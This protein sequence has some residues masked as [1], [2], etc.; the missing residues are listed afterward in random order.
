MARKSEVYTWRVS[1]AMKASLEEAR[2][3][4]HDVLWLGVWE[5]NPHAQKFYERFGFKQVGQHTFLLGTDPQIDWI[6]QRD[7]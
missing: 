6:L 4:G 7:V 1:S 3:R 2:T 5:H